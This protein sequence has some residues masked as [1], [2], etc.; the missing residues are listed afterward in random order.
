MVGDILNA[1]P[2]NEQYNFIMRD[3]GQLDYMYWFYQIS[4]SWQTPGETFSHVILMDRSEEYI[5]IGGHTEVWHE[6]GDLA[7]VSKAG[8]IEKFNIKD[9]RLD[10]Q[11]SFDIGIELIY[12]DIEISRDNEHLF[13]CGHFLYDDPDSAG[14]EQWSVLVMYDRNLFVEE[15]WQFFYTPATQNDELSQIEAHP[16]YD[17]LYGCGH[18]GTGAVMLTML[19]EGNNFAYTLSYAGAR[20]CQTLTIDPTHGLY[21]V[22]GV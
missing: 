4:D 16:L 3:D 22:A 2:G 17:R 15:H 12:K 11:A 19:D 8:W 18:F 21:L 10:H 6:E 9:E 20:T 14:I 5:Y 13:A 1:V 7:P